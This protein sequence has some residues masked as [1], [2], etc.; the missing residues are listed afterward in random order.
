M[1]GNGVMTI[2]KIAAMFLVSILAMNM[3]IPVSSAPKATYDCIAVSSDSVSL[4]PVEKNNKWGFADANG[5]LKIPFKY[6][7]VKSIGNGYYGVNIGNKWGAVN[8]DG[9]LLI[10]T[11]Y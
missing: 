10:D 9:K 7:G 3:L 1:K 4:I 5:K 11:L 2:K 8:K 6:D